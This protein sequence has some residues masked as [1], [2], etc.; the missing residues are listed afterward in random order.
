VRE[1]G[2]RIRSLTGKDEPSDDD[3]V[4]VLLNS[5]RK[6]RQYR[7]LNLILKSRGD[8]LSLG[9]LEEQLISHEDCI[10]D[11]KETEVLA[12]PGKRSAGGRKSSGVPGRCFA[13]GS[14]RHQMLKCPYLD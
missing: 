9:E 4:A 5:I 11:S 12:V 8:A 14:K 1:L 6:N 2:E 7:D 3:L 13:C 10:E